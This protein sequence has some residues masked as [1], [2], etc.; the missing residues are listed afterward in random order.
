MDNKESMF[1]YLDAIRDSG[2]I[3][4]WGAS[5]YLRPAFGLSKIEARAVLLEWMHTQRQKERADT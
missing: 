4:M 5:E 1:E 2:A 3:N